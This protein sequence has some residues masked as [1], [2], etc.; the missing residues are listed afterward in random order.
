MLK[1]WHHIHFWAV[2]DMY[3]LTIS[4]WR[5]W[6]LLDVNGAFFFL[7]ERLLMLQNVKRHV[8]LWPES[9]R[10]C[11]VLWP[12]R[13]CW[14]IRKIDMIL[15]LHHNG[16]MDN[17]VVIKKSSTIRSVLVQLFGIE[18]HIGCKCNLGLCVIDLD[19]I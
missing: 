11:R 18:S 9:P 1:T 19:L 14:P 8:A 13:L 3:L 2:D 10:G 6:M 16:C 17:Y 5:A 12:N 15:L 7:K 4:C